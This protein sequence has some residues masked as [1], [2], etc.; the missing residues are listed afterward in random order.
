MSADSHRQYQPRRYLNR[1]PGASTSKHSARA[2]LMVLC[3]RAEVR[4]TKRQIA[5]MTGLKRTCIGN[6]LRFLKAE[7]S[8]DAVEHQRGGRGNAPTYRLMI[9]DKGRHNT[10]PSRFPIE[11][12]DDAPVGTSESAAASRGEGGFGDNAR[13]RGERA[14][15]AA[16]REARDGDGGDGGP[17]FARPLTGNEEAELRRF[18]RALK[19]AGSYDGAI[20]LMKDWDT[21]RKPEG[22]L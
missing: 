15:Q 17:K 20:R 11:S 6:A 8:I 7:G 9:S 12:I 14:R 10:A 21:G 18:T 5:K 13:A 19:L 22:K 1:V 2:V 3:W 4:I 16:R